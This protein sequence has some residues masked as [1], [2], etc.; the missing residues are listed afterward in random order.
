MTASDRVG[1]RECQTG[2]VPDG[3]VRQESERGR[4]RVEERTA[5]AAALHASWPSVEADPKTRAVA[6]C[7]PTAS[8]VVLGSTQPSA[9]VD[10]RAALTVDVVRRRS[11]G[12]AVFVSPDDPVW[13]DVWVPAG[14]ELWDSDVTRAFDWLG[15]TWV[16]ALDRMGLREL[17]VQGAGPGPST[18]WATLVCFGGV[19]SGEVTIGGRKV[20]GLSQRRARAGS[21]FHSAC[22][23]HWDAE[24]LLGALALSEEERTAASGDLAAAVTGV[25][26]EVAQRSWAVGTGSIG[27]GA[28]GADTRADVIGGGTLPTAEMVT[29][30]FLEG[31]PDG[32]VRI[33]P[34]HSTPG[35]TDR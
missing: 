14:D 3:P 20:V 35:D 6:R 2:R 34:P 18:R 9:A 29:Q 1:S 5:S 28:V 7:R 17:A 11:G 25:A 10:P 32:A 4:W 24:V 15:A 19:S 33:P 12:G 13:L 16:A 31:L 26:D 23:L 30:A 21:W 27:K 22:V 8:A